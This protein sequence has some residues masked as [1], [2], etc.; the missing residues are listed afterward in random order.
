MQTKL[1]DGSVMVCGMLPRDAELKQGT[2]RT[3]KPYTLTTFSVKAGER[4]G[5]A[6][7]VSCQCWH[8]LAR[9]AATLRKGDTVF[10][11]GHI[12]ERSSGDKTYKN[13]VCEFVIAQPTAAE[14][15]GQE[16]TAYSAPPVPTIEPGADYEKFDEQGIPF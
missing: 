10:A 8:E 12:E 13:L 16:L 7:W 3:G 2:S 11:I 14:Q 4:D 6:I 5:E 1:P 9:Y 15:A